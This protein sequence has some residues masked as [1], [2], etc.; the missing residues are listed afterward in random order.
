MAIQIP[1]IV[2]RKIYEICWPIVV[3]CDIDS[4]QLIEPNIMVA[5]HTHNWHQ[6]SKSCRQLSI[7]SQKIVPC[8]CACWHIIV[9]SYIAPYDKDIRFQS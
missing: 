3:N 5:D 2:L 9:I 6:I 1:I 4:W 8:V 7:H